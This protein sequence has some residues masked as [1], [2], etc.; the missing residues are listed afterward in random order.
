M[1]IVDGLR[2]EKGLWA[3]F[4]VRQDPGGLE[5]VSGD[6]ALDLSAEVIKRLD[7]ASGAK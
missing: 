4:G 7:A 1:P 5:L 6:P 2:K 3:I